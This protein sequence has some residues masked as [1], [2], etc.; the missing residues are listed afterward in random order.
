L[1]QEEL[2]RKDYEIGFA[3]SMRLERRLCSE[4]KLCFDGVAR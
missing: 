1:G 3:R 4:G 2:R